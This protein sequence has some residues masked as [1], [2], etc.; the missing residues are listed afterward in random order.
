MSISS[1]LYTGMSS[2]FCLSDKLG[3]IGDNIA[4]VNAT[5]FRAGQI[6]FEDT[7]IEATNTGGVRLS[8]EGIKSDFSTQGSAQPSDIATNMAITGE[9]FFILSDP[10]VTGATYYTRA[11]EFSFDSDGYLANTRGKIVQGYQIDALGTEQTA[12]TDIQLTLSTPAATL[13]DP[14]PVPRLVA[15]PIA[16]TKLTL[17]I[18]ADARSLEHSAG[19]LFGEWDATQAEPM[20]ATA[21]EL[22]SLQDIYDSAGAQHSIAIFFD[23]TAVDKTWEYLITSPPDVPGPPATDGILG[24]GAITFNSNGY[25]EDMT[26]ETG[27]G[28]AAVA[29]NANGYLAFQTPFVGAA[30]IELDLGVSNTAGSWLYAGQTSTQFGYGSYTKFSDTDGYAEG[31]LVRFAVSTDGVINAS[32]DNGVNRDLYRVGLANSNDP[33]SHFKR[34]GY[35]LYQADL[36]SAALIISDRPGLAGLGKIMGSSLETSNVDIA[37]QFGDL[38]FTQRAFQA[39]SKSMVA[40]DEMLKTLI[41][42]KR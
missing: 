33:A 5:G 8:P 20:D 3:T 7:L 17:N 13:W 38:I 29:P 32:F 2:L 26:L 31:D 42:L 21:Y 25:I 10:Q 1:S 19:G 16:S 4:N 41:G 35:S 28:W 6:S 23:K 30:S 14:T 39:N 22:R 9:G 27:S 37:E 18:N 12:L 24:R 40:A 15:D 36:E 11:G 34:I